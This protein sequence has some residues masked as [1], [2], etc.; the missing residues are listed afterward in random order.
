MSEGAPPRQADE[1]DPDHWREVV[2]RLGGEIA[3][4]L[5]AA[6]D[7]VHALATT[8]RIDRQNLRLLLDELEA[9][10]QAGMIGQQL[11]RFGSGRLRQS[12]ERMHLAQTLKGVLAHRARE[13]QGRG[14]ELSLLLRPIEVIADASLLFGLLTSLLDWAMANARAAIEFRIDMKAWP[15]HAQ[16]TCIFE[17]HRPDQ[18]DASGQTLPSSALNS[19]AWY[20][21]QQT[22][23]TMGLPIQRVDEANRTMLTLDFP[24]TIND[25]VEGVSATELD[26]GFAPSAHAKP[27]AGHQVLV[28]A[29]RRDV[30]MQ[31]LEALR[32]MGLIIDFVPSIL[33]AVQFC[34]DGLPHAIIY[35]SALAGERFLQLRQD[36]QG[37]APELAFIEITEEGSS[38][39]MSS[40]TGAET[41][42]VGRDAIVASLPS[43]LI[44]ELS[45]GL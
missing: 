24:R 27:L 37:E 21:V 42:H 22:A 16:L 41:T 11:A 12:H 10:R 7:R 28:I 2:A 4:P 35:E 45:K 32:N 29:S 30:R 36:L 20:L 8:G 40:F 6:L 18:A 25:E 23:W 1:P 14:M 17:P 39:E 34:R 5:T 26:E 43:A 3:G 13:I 38:F 15:S 33:E 31:V 19:I 44:F 9:A